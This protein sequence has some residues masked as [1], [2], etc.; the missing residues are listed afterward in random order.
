MLKKG[1]FE[2]FPAGTLA[3]AIPKWDILR[4]FKLPV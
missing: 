3:Q 2:L 1:K 4:I